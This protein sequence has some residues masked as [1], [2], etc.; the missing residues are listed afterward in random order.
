[1][2][3]GY[4]KADFNPWPWMASDSLFISQILHLMDIINTGRLGHS[5]NHK[6]PQQK[7]P[8]FLESLGRKGLDWIPIN[9]ILTASESFQPRVWGLSDWPGLLARAQPFATLGSSLL[10]PQEMVFFLRFYY[11]KQKEEALK[12]MEVWYRHGFC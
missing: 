7:R 3:L 6:K 1:M 12:S 2:K 4:P 9:L 11:W 5:L 10:Q 8:S